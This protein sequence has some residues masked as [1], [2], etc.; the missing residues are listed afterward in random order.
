MKG[1]SKKPIMGSLRGASPLFLVIPLPRWGSHTDNRPSGFQLRLRQIEYLRR[2]GSPNI[3]LIRE[4]VH[5]DAEQLENSPVVTCHNCL[6]LLGIIPLPELRRSND[7]LEYR[8]SSLDF[9]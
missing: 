3:D 9:Q 1:K 7:T 6:L 4:D 5:P 8:T 2:Y